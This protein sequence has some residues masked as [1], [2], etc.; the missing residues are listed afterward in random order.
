MA[1]QADD[2]KPPFLTKGDEC[3]RLYPAATWEVYEERILEAASFDPDG[4]DLVRSITAWSSPCPVDR[5]GRI[6]ISQELREHAKLER[7]AV[8][9]GM[10]H[11]VEIWNPTRWSETD[12]RTWARSRDLRRSLAAKIQTKGFAKL[13]GPEGST[14]SG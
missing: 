6:L 4:E 9:V 11:F 5:V 12:A 10:G 7:E 3:L 8:F 1:L 13:G 2:T 14:P